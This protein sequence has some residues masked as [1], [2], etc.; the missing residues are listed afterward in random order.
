MQPSALPYAHGIPI[1]TGRI[2]QQ[3]EDF[4]VEEILGFVPSGVGE[5]IFLKIEKQGE[6]TDFLARQLAKFAGLPRQAVSYAGLK[7]RHGR[8]IQWFGVHL[9]GKREI[10]WKPME[11]ATLRVLDVTRN[12]RKL[13][14]GA[15]RGNRFQIALRDV[16][17]EA[18]RVDERLSVLSKSGVPNYFGPQRFGRNGQN[19]SSALAMFK[20]EFS[21]RDR[22]LRGIYLSAARSELFNRVLAQRVREDSWDK[23]IAGDVF[24]FADSRSFFSDEITPDIERRIAELLIHSS[25]PLWGRGDLPSGDRIRGI[26]QA[27]ADEMPE[28]TAGLI[29]S[30]LE[31]ERRPLRL[32][33]SDLTWTW[34]DTMTL[35]LTFSLPAGCYATTVLRE[36]LDFEGDLD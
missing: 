27:V 7:D 36:L 5:H 19:L 24:M 10:D 15:L 25:G 12:D 11:T 26:E 18:N 20:G 1:I 21:P 8:T 22:H 31:M 9:P 29:D 23:A 30:G 35:R 34:L 6:N 2:K 13:K 32:P 3:P 14:I 16:K 33:V 17:G 28:L 4:I